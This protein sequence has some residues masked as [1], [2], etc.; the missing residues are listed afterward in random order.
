MR[1]LTHLKD[2]AGATTAEYSVC[3]GVGVGF[4]G[5]LWKFLTSDSGQHFISNVFDKITSILPF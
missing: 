3:T 5:V 2:E 1:N 4:A